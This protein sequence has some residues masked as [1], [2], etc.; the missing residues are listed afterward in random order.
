MT[1]SPYDFT[2]Y[3]FE[4]GSRELSAKSDRK[5]ELENMINTKAMSLLGTAEEQCRELEKKR[6][7]LEVDKHQLF[8][9][10]KV[11]VS[12]YIQNDS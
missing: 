7:Q 5:K 8:D 12:G 3:T 2:N 9:A 4:A 11:G 1:G 10:I 6:A